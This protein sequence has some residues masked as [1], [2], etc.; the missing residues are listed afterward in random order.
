MKENLTVKE[1]L[2]VFEG[3]FPKGRANDQPCRHSDAFCYIKEG[4]IEYTFSGKKVRAKEKNL[5]FSRRAV[6]TALTLYR[7][8]SIYVSTLISNRAHLLQ[9]AL[10]LKMF[11]PTSE[12]FSLSF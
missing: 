11:L 7:P 1:I 12:I 5:F 8:L 4:E 9:M 2:K 6:P 3:S 10:F